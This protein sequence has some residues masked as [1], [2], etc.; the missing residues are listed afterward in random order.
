MVTA[1]NEMKM[2]RHRAAAGPVQLRRG[3]Q[4]VNHA[5]SRGMQVRGPHPGLALAAARLD[6]EHER[7]RAA[8]GD[9]QPRHP[10]GDPLQRAGS[11][12]GRGE[13]G[14]RR[15]QRGG[16]RDSNLQRTG[17]DWIE[18]AFRAA[19][20]PTRT[21]SSATTTT[22][23]TT[24]PGRRPRA[25]TTWCATS[26]LAACRSTASASSRTST[27]ARRT[28]ATTAPRCQNFAALGVDVQITELDIQGAYRRTDLRQRGQGLPGRVPLQRHHGV[29]HP[30]QRLVAVRRTPL[31]F[32]SNG[33][34]KP[35]YDAVLDALNDGTTPTDPPTDHAAHRPADRSA[36]DAASGSRR[37]ARRRCR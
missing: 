32:D 8:P 17:N 34:K 10:G 2:R 20:P 4:I 25:S 21:P 22:T 12:L 19:A 7:Q 5:R 29:G 15:Q 35:A 27:A 30:R 26:R 6:A 18:A 36:H 13:R 28:R 1:E 23:P 37:A 16:R 11:G 31:L 9:A 33:S 24:G 3:D 14:V